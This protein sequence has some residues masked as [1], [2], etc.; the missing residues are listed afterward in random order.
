MHQRKLA[1]LHTGAQTSPG[2]EGKSSRESQKRG[3]RG[4]FFHI[5]QSKTLLK[6][7]VLILDR[8]AYK[9]LLNFTFRCSM[10]LSTQSILINVKLY[11]ANQIFNLDVEF[12]GDNFKCC[13]E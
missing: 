4:K 9:I 7:K 3:R 5:L 8:K 12:A 10:A 13:M 11:L 1:G 6:R 2:K